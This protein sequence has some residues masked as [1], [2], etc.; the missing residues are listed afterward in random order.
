[1]LEEVCDPLG[2]TVRG[3]VVPAQ[4]EKGQG[5]L[6]MSCFPQRHGKRRG[7]EWGRP[8]VAREL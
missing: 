4:A 8:G 3:T 2:P 7:S 1:M 5:V 6:R